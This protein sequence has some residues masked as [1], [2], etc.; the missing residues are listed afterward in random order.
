MSPILSIGATAYS[1]SLICVSLADGAPQADVKAL[2]GAYNATNDWTNIVAL[3]KSF[4]VRLE[5]IIPTY[6]KNVVYSERNADEVISK[7]AALQK[8][9]P[10][11]KT[12]VEAFAQKYGREREA[13]DNKME[14]LKNP[15]NPRPSPPAGECFEE[16]SNGLINL[17]EAPKLEAKKILAAVLQ[18]LD[19]IE[20]FTADTERDK[21]YAEA[22]ARLRLGLK[23]NPTDQEIKDWVVTIA[24]MR[25][26]SKADIEAAMDSARTQTADMK[27]QIR[28]RTRMLLHDRLSIQVSLY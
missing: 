6:V 13:I 12:Q 8:E 7:I 28:S 20:S 3:H 14:Q 23:F 5:E 15:Q 22:D 24:V 4:I 11:V 19:R 17:E 18:N 26:K 16:L 27:R 2:A 1:L 21:S 10:Y 9:A 25:H